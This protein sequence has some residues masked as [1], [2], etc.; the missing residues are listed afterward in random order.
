MQENLTGYSYSLDTTPYIVQ[1][2]KRDLGSVAPLRF[3]QY[4]LN[5]RQVP[6]FEAV[7]PDGHGVFESLNA[8]CRLVLANLRAKQQRGV[9]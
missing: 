7:A 4:V 3:M 1:Y 6:Y 9:L 8:V 2:N 5:P